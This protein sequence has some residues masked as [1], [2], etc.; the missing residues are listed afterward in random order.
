MCK[1]TSKLDLKK[2]LNMEIPKWIIS[3]FDVE[4]ESENLDNSLKRHLLKRP[5]ISKWSLR[6][7]LKELDVTVWTKKL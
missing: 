2:L 1:K 5:T 4:I 3:L 7:H 6:I